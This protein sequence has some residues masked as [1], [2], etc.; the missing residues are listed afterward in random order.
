MKMYPQNKP[1]TSAGRPKKKDEPSFFDSVYAVVR[2]VPYG[3]VTTYG[4]VAE[5]TGL[6]MSAR[7]VGWALSTCAHVQPRI[8]A[9]RVVNRLGVL[10]GRHHF[11]TPTLMQEL[12]EQ[13]GVKVKDDTVVD[14]KQLFWDPRSA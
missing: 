5:A 13:E 4:A 9:H 8:P 3:R 10:S 12:L 7:M 11:A 1:K 2:Q 6:R 14:F